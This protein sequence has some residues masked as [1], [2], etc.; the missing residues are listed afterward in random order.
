ME[1]I[2]YLAQV[3]NGL[4]IVSN[5][6]LILL[7]ITAIGMTIYCCSECDPE[8]EPDKRFFKVTRR[9][10][11]GLAIAILGVIFVPSKQTYLF[12]VG[13]RVVDKTIENNPQIKDIPG[14]TLDLLN[15]YIK[16][17]TEKLREKNTPKE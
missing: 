7:G 1:K 9:L 4:N 17:S 12:M 5:I 2:F 14:N 16:T 10:W 6:L 8:Y 13:G 11:V 15:E 3:F